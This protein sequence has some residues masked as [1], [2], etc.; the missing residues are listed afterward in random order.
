MN[1]RAISSEQ[2]WQET[3][4]TGRPNL[5]LRTRA[6]RQRFGRPVG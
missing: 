6:E 4:K 2:A 1:V 3:E 5:D